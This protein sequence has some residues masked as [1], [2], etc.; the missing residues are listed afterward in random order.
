[1]NPKF[2]DY[3]NYQ[4]TASAI[5]DY[6]VDLKEEKNPSIYIIDRMSN[7]VNQ[8]KFNIVGDVIRFAVKNFNK[9]DFYFRVK[10]DK[11]HTD[12]KTGRSYL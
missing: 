1:M 12:E 6:L 9:D 11:Y 10:P 4:S 2:D 8:K 3:L 5:P 7:F